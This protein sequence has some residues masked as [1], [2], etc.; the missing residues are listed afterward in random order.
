M[1]HPLA[2]TGHRN[3]ANGMSAGDHVRYCIDGRT[4]IADEFLSNGDTFV[5][6]DDGTH[7]IVKWN[8]LE[9]AP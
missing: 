2:L 9:P 3:G 4:G 5:T 6:W 1:T 7:D 8:Y